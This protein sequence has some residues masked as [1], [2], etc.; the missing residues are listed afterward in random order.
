MGFYSPVLSVASAGNAMC[1][2]KFQCQF[3]SL[4][5][6][7]CGKR[8]YEATNSL[9]CVKL[10]LDCS[11]NRNDQIYKLV[12]YMECVTYNFLHGW[13]AMETHLV[14]N[15]CFEQGRILFNL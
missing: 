11:K 12:R 1:S 4:A 14:Y 5:P 15:L 10:P 6:S 13:C 7:V 2:F 9:G 8:G 3:P